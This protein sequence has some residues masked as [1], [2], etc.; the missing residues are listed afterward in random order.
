M[1]DYKGKLHKVKI[2]TLKLGGSSDDTITIA[3]VKCPVPKGVPG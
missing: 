3:R 1:V 2:Q